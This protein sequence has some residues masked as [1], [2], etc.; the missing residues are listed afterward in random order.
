MKL[1]RTLMLLSDPAVEQSEVWQQAIENVERAVQAIVWP[2]HADEFTIH[3]KKSVNGVKPIKKAFVHSL[4]VDGWKPEQRKV[5]GSGPV[6]ALLTIQGQA[7]ALEWETGNISSSHRSLNRM[8]LG[9]IQEAVVGGI[10]VLPSHAFY[11]YLTDRVGNWRELEPFFT[12]WQRLPIKGALA[13][14][15]VEHDALDVE[16]A[17]IP[18]G[19]DGWALVERPLSPDGQ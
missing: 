10:L 14:V 12:I 1:L 3:P 13:V 11:Y 8:C 18:K 5:L 19:T 2:P 4:E 15:E 9:M 16:V 7:V 6:D 17:P